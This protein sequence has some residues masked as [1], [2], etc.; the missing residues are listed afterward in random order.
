MRHDGL[1]LATAVGPRSGKTIKHDLKIF[2]KGKNLLQNG[3]LATL[4]RLS[5]SLE[6]KYVNSGMLVLGT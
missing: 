1:S 3:V 6:I 4:L 5:Q 2:E